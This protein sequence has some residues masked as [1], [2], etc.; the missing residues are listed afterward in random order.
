MFHHKQNVV[1][2]TDEPVKDR[3]K[4]WCNRQTADYSFLKY[5]SLFHSSDSIRSP[6][7]CSELEMPRLLPGKVIATE[8]SVARRL[9]VNGAFEIQ[10][11]ASKEAMVS[12]IRMSSTVALL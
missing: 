11:S 8:M 7:I 12:T 4:T 6:W 5:E 9:E 3:K 10:I 1:N 2:E